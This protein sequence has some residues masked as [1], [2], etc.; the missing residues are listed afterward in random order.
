MA[1]LEML[2]K[3]RALFSGVDRGLQ[4]NFSSLPCNLVHVL[5]CAHTYG[6]FLNSLLTSNF[7]ISAA[8]VLPNRDSLFLGERIIA[9][10][11]RCADT[12]T[13]VRKISIQVCLIHDIFKFIKLIK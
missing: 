2:T 10:L 11:P 1:V 13:E 9:Y 5:Q 7:D 6:F 12:S 3:F 4:R 8:F